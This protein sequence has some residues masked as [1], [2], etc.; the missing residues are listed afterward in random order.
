MKTLFA[1]FIAVCLVS[2]AF[3]ADYTPRSAEDG[4][5]SVAAA[6]VT[7]SGIVRLTPTLVN[8][9]DGQTNTLAAGAYLVSGTG[10][11]ND[12]TNTVVL[13]NPTTAGDRVLIVMAAATTNLITIADSGNVAASGAILLD[14]NDAVEL[15]AP[16]TSL[17]VEVPGDN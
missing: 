4:S 5:Q 3:A 1:S 16:T 6:N 12:T 7:V 9:T 8:W 14:A 2:A 10:G 11:A 17:W 15:Y 13:A